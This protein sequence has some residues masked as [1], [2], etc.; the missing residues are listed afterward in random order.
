VPV[1]PPVEADQDVQ[2]AEKAEP[3]APLQ[4]ARLSKALPAAEALP[5][6]LPA[7]LEL[8]EEPE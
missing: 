4:A 8:P 3:D 6:A 5:R 1:V 7:A 2:Q